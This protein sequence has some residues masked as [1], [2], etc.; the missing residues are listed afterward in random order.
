MQS[1]IT[2]HRARLEQ[3]HYITDA[4]TKTMFF[5]FYESRFTD[6][7][8]NYGYEFC[9]V[10]NGS[11]K[12]NDAFIMPFQDFRDFF[13][14]EL[15]DATHR[16][17]GNIRLHDENVVI[18]AHGVSKER[19]AFEYHNAFHLLQDAPLPLPME[20]DVDEFV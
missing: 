9:L 4:T 6:Y 3:R 2:Y 19:A 10:I 16:W 8:S 15:L 18:S 14:P 20:P 7:I 1:Y 17:V 5:N 11:S 12:C 13:T